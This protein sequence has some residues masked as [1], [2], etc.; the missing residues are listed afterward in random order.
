[1][2]HRILSL[3][4]LTASILPAQEKFEAALLLGLA[5]PKTVTFGDNSTFKDTWKAA[6][7]KP[8]LRIEIAFPLSQESSPDWRDTSFSNLIK[9]TAP[10]SHVQL[11]GGFR[12]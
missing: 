2:K 7:T 3:L 10:R 8:F 6:K 5:S 11:A 12:F 1:M 4:C 9:A